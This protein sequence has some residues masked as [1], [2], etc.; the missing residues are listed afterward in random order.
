MGKNTLQNNASLVQ[1]TLRKRWCIPDKY[2]TNHY[3]L[4]PCKYLFF[5]H[6]NWLNYHF[7]KIY[8]DFNHKFKIMKFHKYILRMNTCIINL[9]I[10]VL[11]LNILIFDNFHLD[12]EML[13]VKGKNW[14]LQR[15]LQGNLGSNL[16]CVNL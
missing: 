10:C 8:V 12:R 11:K 14:K 2:S 3:L 15:I 1:Q 16:L 5:L 13:Q 7:E 4:T 6:A 9:L